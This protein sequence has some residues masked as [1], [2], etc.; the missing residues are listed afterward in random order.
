MHLGKTSIEGQ[1]YMELDKCKIPVQE[2]GS[3]NI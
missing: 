2:V 1:Y 3:K